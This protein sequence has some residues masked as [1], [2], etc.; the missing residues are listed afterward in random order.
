MIK[1]TIVDNI[2]TTQL[3]VFRTEEN[4]I[5]LYLSDSENQ[6]DYYSV[7]Y[8]DLDINDTEFLIKQLNR[9]TKHIQYIKSM[10]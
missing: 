5:R 4:T 7:Q 9:L 2:T 1:Q 8:I 10:N 6:D 3:E